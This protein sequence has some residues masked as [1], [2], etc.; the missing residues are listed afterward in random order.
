MKVKEESEK[1]GLKLIQKTKIM[2]S[3]PI[4]S[5]QIDGETVADFI[6]GGSKITADGDCSREIKRRFLFGRKAMTNLVQF[7]SVSQS[8]PTLCDPMNCS[9][10][11]LPVHHQL[12]ESTQT[13]VH[14]VGDAVQPSPF[15]LSL[16]PPVL[17]LSEHQGLLNWVSSSH[18]VAKRLK[19]QL[20]QQSFQWTPRTDL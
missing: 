3:G 8:C 2:A 1:P 7:T 20:Q 5:L 16:S 9:M 6:F 12:P 19:F 11:C 17:N 13:H 4:S 18:Q 10:A 14:W 15:L